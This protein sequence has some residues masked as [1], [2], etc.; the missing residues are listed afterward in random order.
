V[1]SAA[2][3]KS[4]SES[5]VVQSYLVW[6]GSE[7]EDTFAMVSELPISDEALTELDAGLGSASDAKTLGDFIDEQE[8][9]VEIFDV[10]P[11]RVMPLTSALPEEEELPVLVKWGDEIKLAR[12]LDAVPFKEDEIEC[13]ECGDDDPSQAKDLPHRFHAWFGSLPRGPYSGLV[14]GPYAGFLD[15]SVNILPSSSIPVSSDDDE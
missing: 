14:D 6:D 9:N 12:S 2:E 8:K 3:V 11:Y 13:L 4:Q 10:N 7:P 15:V 5:R 1:F